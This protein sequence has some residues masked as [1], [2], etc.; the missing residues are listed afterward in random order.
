[1]T[2]Q[3]VTISELISR[4]RDELGELY[5]ERE[6]RNLF[7]LLMEQLNYKK[8]EIYLNLSANLKDREQNWML[9]AL[10][11]L[12]NHVPVQYILGHTWFCG[13]KM[14]VK[15]GVLIPRP[16][17]EELVLWVLRENDSR[18]RRVID[19][20]CGSGCIALALKEQ[21]P[22]WKITGVDA[23]ERALACS[24]INGKELQLD[25]GWIKGDILDPVF[26]PALGQ[27]DVA[28]SNPPYIPEHEKNSLSPHVV[29]AEPGQALFVPDQDPLLFYRALEEFGRSRLA[30]GGAI[31]VEMH[32]KMMEPLTGL[33]IEKGWEQVTPARDIHGRWRMLRAC[34]QRERDS[35]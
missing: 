7:H 29:H 24:R 15:P 10:E 31:Y 2:V 1:M 30:P 19:I 14:G 5:P 33:F 35:L 25:V 17:T 13:L 8:T 9:D 20:G 21:R 18:S 6:I 32:E 22:A 26:W 3:P 4:F 34:R 12:K 16:E 11:R 23:D 27:Y 28:V